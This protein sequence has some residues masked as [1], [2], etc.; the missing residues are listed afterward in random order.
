MNTSI[1]VWGECD[2]SLTKSIIDSYQSIFDNHSKRCLSHE[3]VVNVVGTMY[4][5]KEEVA[6][7]LNPDSH[8]YDMLL[9]LKLILAVNCK[10]IRFKISFG[11]DATDQNQ[12]YDLCRTFNHGKRFHRI[13][14]AFPRHPTEGRKIQS[15]SQLLNKAF[16]TAKNI[17]ST[18]TGIFYVFLHVSKK[19]VSQKD[20]WKLDYDDDWLLIKEIIFTRAQIKQILPDYQFRC[21]D[22]KR[23]K[24][25]YVGVYSFQLKSRNITKSVESWSQLDKQLMNIKDNHINTDDSDIDNDSLSEERDE[26]SDDSCSDSS[27]DSSN[28]SSDDDDDDDYEL[29]WVDSIACSEAA[30]RRIINIFGNPVPIDSLHNALKDCIQ[31]GTSRQSNSNKSNWIYQDS[32]HKFVVQNPGTDNAVIVHAERRS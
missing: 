1:L 20:T 8:S 23:W 16:E 9:N 2:F 21:H 32:C 15:N 11:I 7:A 30:Q 25:D 18:K 10:Q 31:E 29:E 24:P 13:F 27:N 19:L 28:D 5:S 17:L 3:N 4:Q 26:E 12:N 22:G 14:F 6:A